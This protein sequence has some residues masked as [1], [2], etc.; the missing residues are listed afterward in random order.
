MLQLILSLLLPLLAVW[1][2]WTLLYRVC[3]HPLADVP[4]PLLGRM[5]HFYSFWHNINGGRF[6]L[7]IPEL[8]AKYGW[9]SF[10]T[11]QP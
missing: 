10:D 8:H 1:G 3:F 2:V 5:F 9:H 11:W 4:G 7:K 6:Y